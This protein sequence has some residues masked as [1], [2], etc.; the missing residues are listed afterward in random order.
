MEP[1][2]QRPAVVRGLDR[3]VLAHGCS[4]RAGESVW[5]DRVALAQQW[6]PVHGALVVAVRNA[7]HIFGEEVQGHALGIGEERPKLRVSMR[8][9]NGRGIDRPGGD[10]RAANSRNGHQGQ[11]Q[12]AACEPLCRVPSHIVE[13]SIVLRRKHSPA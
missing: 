10:C 9:Q 4:D 7:G 13:S 6:R 5:Q 2:V 12:A 11:D 3:T 8:S 1:V